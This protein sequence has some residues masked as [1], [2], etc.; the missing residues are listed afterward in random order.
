MLDLQLLSMNP[1]PPPSFDLIG[2]L[3]LTLTRAVRLPV[4]SSLEMSLSTLLVLL[5]SVRAERNGASRISNI[6]GQFVH[7]S[8]LCGTVFLSVCV[9]ALFLTLVLCLC[10]PDWTGGSG[11]LSR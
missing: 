9:T 4:R 6:G 1:N 5:T 7:L 11:G 3:V 10:S 8:L 2:R